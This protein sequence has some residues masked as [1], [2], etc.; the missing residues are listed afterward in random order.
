MKMDIYNSDHDSNTHRLI[1][2]LGHT[3]LSADCIALGLPSR[4]TF[5]NSKIADEFEYEIVDQVPEVIFDRSQIAL[6]IE[7]SIS[8]ALQTMTIFNLLCVIFFRSVL[9]DYIRADTPNN[10]SSHLAFYQTNL[11]WFD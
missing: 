6:S 9:S 5:E 4:N 8:Y 11:S 1:S 7:I 3:G 2:L 10:S